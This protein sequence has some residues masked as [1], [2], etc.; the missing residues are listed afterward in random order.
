MQEYYDNFFE[1]VFVETNDKVAVSRSSCLHAEWRENR[2]N[3]V[4]R[5]KACSHCQ[6]LRSIKVD[7]VELCGGVHSALRQQCHCCNLSVS[8]S[9]SVSGSVNAPLRPIHTWRLLLPHC[10]SLT[11]CQWQRKHWGRGLRPNLCVCVCVTVDTMLNFDGDVDA[12]TD[13]KC[14]QNISNGLFTR[15]VKVTEPWTHG[16]SVDRHGSFTLP[17]T[18]SG[19]CPT[20][21]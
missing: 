1:E 14:E 20:Q 10:P 2:L 15:S 3:A 11:L 7:C 13:V 8:V 5:P 18:D 9:V 21:K 16:Q 17:E 4:Y 19:S 6:T 12:N